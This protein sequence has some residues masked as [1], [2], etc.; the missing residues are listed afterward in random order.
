MLCVLLSR[1]CVSVDIASLN[2]R[3]Q[4]SSC[5]VV[6]NTVQGRN[7]SNFFVPSRQTNA[8]ALPKPDFG[9]HSNWPPRLQQAPIGAKGDNFVTP[10]IH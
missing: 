6:T 5:T 9:R 7:I 3:A 2:E 10:D 4:V 8:T 1:M